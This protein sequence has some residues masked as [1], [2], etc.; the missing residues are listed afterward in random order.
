MLK[1]KIIDTIIED[2]SK[3]FHVEVTKDQIEYLKKWLNEHFK[4]LGVT[5]EFS[6]HFLERV[7]SDRNSPPITAKELVQ[8]FNREMR[9]HGKTIAKMRPGQEGIL[10]DLS[11][12]IN[13]PIVIKWS[14]RHGTIQMMN[15]TIM[16]K[17]DFGNDNQKYAGDVVLKV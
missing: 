12:D 2:V 5:V 4:K 8:I 7:N 10:K 17:K 16:R 9:A 11:T 13:V 6:S 14:D 15:K 3:S 1:Q